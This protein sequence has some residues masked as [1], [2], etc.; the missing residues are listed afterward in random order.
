[1]VR[2]VDAEPRLAAFWPERFPFF[3]G[4]EADAT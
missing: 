4:W 3:D 1:V 2:A